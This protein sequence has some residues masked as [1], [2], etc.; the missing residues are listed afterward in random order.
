EGDQWRRQRL[1]IQEAFTP[2]QIESY[3][4]AMVAQARAATQGWDD[5]EELDLK[6]AISDLTLRILSRT[7]FDID[8]DD[9]GEV[10]RRAA[11]ALNG[12]ANA[13]N[14]SAFIPTWI[15][16]PTN[17][18]LHRTMEDMEALLD[19]LLD[20]RRASAAERDDLLS[21]LL[22]AE[23]ADGSAL[24][25]REIK[26]QLIT[27]IFAGHETTALA[28]T[29]ALHALGHHPEKRTKLREE[30]QVVTGGDPPEMSDLPELNFTEQVINE[31]LRL[32]PPSYAI[33]RQATEETEIGGYR[34]PE[35]SKVTVPQIHVHRDERFYENPDAF[36][37]GRWSEEFEESLPEYAFFP[38]GGGP[39]HCIGMRFAMME[40]KLTLP[41]ILSAVT[42]EPKGEPGLD[43][44]T[45]VTL[46]PAEPIDAIV[47]DH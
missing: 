41:T 35:G 29:Y 31:T 38:F 2:R 37:P 40:L 17:R 11:K 36:R 34:V 20:E 1:L 9:R 10:I 32:Y 42:I 12:R 19:D 33:F 23:T 3:A 14:L 27:F 4:D 47:R 6:E 15:P 24:S 43:F 30:I 46:Q 26:D 25:D 22:S 5:G 44:D 18:R 8:L 13:Q 45:G 39:R 16:T 21:L 7:L 28:L